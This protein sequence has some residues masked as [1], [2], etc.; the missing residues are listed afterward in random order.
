MKKGLLLIFLMSAAF[1][2]SV[3]KGSAFKPVGLQCEYLSSPLGIEVKEPR[4]SWQL[5]DE[6]H[7]RGQAQTSYHIMVASSRKLLA[8]GEADVWDSGKV[9]SPQS[10]MIYFGGEELLSSHEYFW[11]VRI[12]DKDGN[13]S[14]WSEP[15][16]FVTGVLEA[17]EWKEAEWI[18]HPSAEN[19][20]HIWFR[21]NIS[22]GNNP[23]AIF[24]HVASLGHHEL[25]VNGQKIDDGV[26]APA[27][28]DFQK[29]L[30]YI[31]YDISKLL[32]KG[33]NTIAV[34][35]AP[36]W[37]IYDCFK[38]TPLL[39]VKVNGLDVDQNPVAI[40]S[41]STWKCEI[42]NSEA[43]V[44][45]NTF[46]NNGGEIVD[47]GK[48]N[49]DW[50]KS[51]FDDSQWNNSATQDFNIALN[52]Q[53]IPPSRLI[54]K[55]SVR[56]ITDL[57]G[58]KYKIDFGKN[59]TGWVNI[60]F[61]GLSPGDTV[62]I[63]S[64]D[65]DKSFCDFNMRSFFI[66]SGQSGETFQNRFNY[67]A[68]RYLNLE[69]LKNPPRPEDATAYALSTDLKRTGSFKSSND[70]FNRI[71][72]ADIWTFL[73]NTQEG[74]TSDCPHRERCGY[75]EVATA[76]SWGLALPNFDAGAYYKKVIRDWTDVQTEDGWGRNV[77]P[78]PNDVHWGGA[79]WSSAGINLAEHHYQHY[80]DIEII[81]LIYPSAQKWLE[82]LHNN[83]NKDGLL[84]PYRNN[85]GQFLGDWLAPHSRSEF[86]D[87]INAV[88]FN[89]CVYVMN[90]QTMI[91]FSTLLNRQD[92]VK[93]YAGR[94]SQL[95]PAI[96]SKFYKPDSAIYQ[97]GTQVQNAFAL[98]TGIT[99]ESERKRVAEYIHNDMN[100]AHPYFDMGSSGLSVL[101]KYLVATPEENET[102]ARIL[103]STEFPG[104]GY[105]ISQGE[106]TWP[107]DWKIEVES[108]IHTCY[109]GIA[110]WLIKGLCGI[111][112]DPAHPGY[113]S[114]TIRPAIVPQTNFAEATVESPV[115]QIFSRWER[116]GKQ[117]TLSVIIPPGSEAK[118]H[119]PAAMPKNILE[120]GLDI[121]KS[122]DITVEGFKDGYTIVALS[123]GRY[124]F[125]SEL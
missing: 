125:S 23:Q 19:V 123:S 44:A 28:T 53:D 95:K 51:G 63:N 11:K 107:E 40:N 4:F 100:G 71:Y 75:G 41:D 34:W 116:K 3:P 73:S 124:N 10:S 68:G 79:M 52:S 81:K 9:N 80:G 121:E 77:A 49:P 37:A 62:T 92:D 86:G 112:P 104:Y 60:R 111:Q 113:K 36:G 15:E 119:I 84:Q 120:S 117:L 102:T 50:N 14:A 25:Y 24:A 17:S 91:R 33:E 12:F 103:N 110:G 109:T 70:L 29:R 32:K 39:K 43:T 1:A 69:G 66:S 96:Q 59:F 94:L 13:P 38:M 115:G 45:V 48:Y 89:N 78:Q 58:G 118:V 85:N 27:L 87:N 7:T 16:R 18:R 8:K 88:F 90:L 74:Y 76:C 83:T 5:S 35:F 55:L 57:G 122:P 54:E 47:A 26:L 99:P 65:D 93:L 22:L 46:G 21:K 108:K 114:F 30:F 31:T 98:L 61:N 106:T 97:S 2:C 67:T 101:L 56:S 64:A 6:S 20:K 105:F 72:E 82:F 42:S